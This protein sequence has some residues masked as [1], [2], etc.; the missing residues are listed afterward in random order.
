MDILGGGLVGRPAEEIGKL[1][2]VADILVLSLGA[3]PADRHVLDQSPAYRADGLVG[4]WGLL[5]W[6]RFKAPQ[7][8]D[9]TSA[10]RYSRNP[11]SCHRLPRSGFVHRR[12]LPLA[13]R[14]GERLFVEPTT[15]VR[16]QQRD[17]R[18]HLDRCLL[19][20][21]PTPWQPPHSKLDRG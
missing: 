9:R 13:A 2:D 19:R 21:G 12:I 14:R 20:L 5:S 3:E 7:S 8:Q 18:H 1:F 17:R 4:H 16:C 6:V 10:S 15:A 11:S